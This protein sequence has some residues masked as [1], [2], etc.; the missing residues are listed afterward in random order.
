MKNPDSW[1]G[2]LLIIYYALFQ[3]IHFVVNAL[4][5]VGFA[6]GHAAFP[7][8]PP[9]AGWA[10]QTVHF[11]IAMAALDAVNALLTL[12]FTYAY[13]RRRHWR[14]WLGTTV[15]TVSVYAAL[16]FDYATLASGAW[17][18]NLAGYLLINITFLPVL[19]LAILWSRW[20]AAGYV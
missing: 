5:F 14:S 19:A 6:R 4:A 9:P 18:P 12:F 20:R 3:A 15:L 8:L 1:P 17:L 7:A 2:R 13:F 16:L 11:F 10:A